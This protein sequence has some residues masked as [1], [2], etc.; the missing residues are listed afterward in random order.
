MKRIGFL[1]I[2]ALVGVAA[3]ASGC[4]ITPMHKELKAPAKLAQGNVTTAATATGM[5][6]GKVGWGR[7]TLFAIPVAPVHVEGD[8]S[9]DTMNFVRDALTTAGY[10]VDAVNAG[11][12]APGPVLSVG[13]KQYKFNNYT[14]LAPLIF[15]WGRIE[16]DA[17]L[18]GPDDHVLW[19]KSYLGK[20]TSVHITEGFTN[21]ASKCMTR[22][23]DQM[24]VDFGTPAFAGAL[25]GIPAN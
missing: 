4:S 17:T 25:I 1:W 13:I 15:S 16:L 12:H 24:V 8:A 3:L 7:I 19:T 20:G 10:T 21:S 18:R 14:W 9:R 5:P 11:A 2:P 23:L 6:S 22:V